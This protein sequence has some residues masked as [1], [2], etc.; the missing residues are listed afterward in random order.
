MYLCLYFLPK[1]RHVVIDVS[2]LANTFSTM[3]AEVTQGSA[4]TP[5]KLEEP[6]ESESVNVKTIFKNALGDAKSVV[7]TTDWNAFFLRI[8]K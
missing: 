5:I 6:D 4:K 8:I 3:S 1:L 7:Q 2:Y